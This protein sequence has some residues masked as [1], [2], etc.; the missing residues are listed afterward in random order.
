MSLARGETTSA[1]HQLASEIKMQ[2]VRSCYQTLVHHTPNGIL[3]CVGPKD[4]VLVRVHEMELQIVQKAGLHRLK[5]GV[6]L[7]CPLQ[8][9]LASCLSTGARQ[10]QHLS[11]RSSHFRKS[12]DVLPI[13]VAKS[14][15]CA[16]PGDVRGS[17][18]LLQSPDLS[19]RWSA[20][21]VSQVW[22]QNFTFVS[23]MCAFDKWH[24]TCKSRNHW[25][26]C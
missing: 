11:Q 25:R 15:E 16:K 23:N 18:P 1:A 6:G 9:L 10:A 12:L 7:R 17:R 4:E 20:T 21:A 8:F 2:Q 26:T 14:K 24:T 22:P 13:P 19:R 5:G 3:G